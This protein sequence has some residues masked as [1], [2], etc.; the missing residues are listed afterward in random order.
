MSKQCNYPSCTRQAIYRLE[1]RY[2]E[3]PS[4]FR[5]K[6]CTLRVPDVTARDIQLA[7]I[8]CVAAVD[9][10]TRKPPWAMMIICYAASAY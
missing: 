9:A 3:W 1:Y 2:E 7:L 6:Y 8:A 4:W 10:D 5:R